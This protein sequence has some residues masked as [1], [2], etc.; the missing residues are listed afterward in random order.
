MR[1][2][3]S[4]QDY[5]L[6]DAT[7]GERLE[8]F[9]DIIL[10]RPDPQIIWKSAK[11]SPLWSKAHARYIRSNQGGG[12]WEVLAK[13]P[14]SWAIKYNDLTFMV[15]LMGFKHTGV[16]P[17][18][19]A[20]WDLFGKLIKKRLQ[21]SPNSGEQPTANPPK[22][23]NLF[24][25]TGCATLAC[26]Q[27]GASVCHVDASKGMV[28]WGKENAELSHLSQKPVRWIVDDCMKFVQREIR[29]GNKYDGVIMDPPS[30]GR[31][32]GGEVWKLEDSVSSFVQLCAQVLSDN[33]LFFAIN[34]YSTGLSGGVMQY[35]LEDILSPV[36]GGTVNSEEIG[37]PVQSTNSI[38]PCGSTALWQQ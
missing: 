27:A 7:D 33:P 4:W 17:E 12:H 38:L 15:K 18:Q 2:A 34:S 35:I 3:D 25:Y 16:F 32:P 6:L 30:Y 21:N 14:Q 24:G 10:I 11:R 26:L 8:M 13:L 19:A 5:K 23:L 36:F 28:A 20:N 37:L 31:G 9:G 22:V 1:I 29:R